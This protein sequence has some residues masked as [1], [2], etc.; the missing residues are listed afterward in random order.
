MNLL[1]QHPAITAIV[2]YW[3]F[4]SVV[5]GM[6]APT[7]SSSASYVWLHDSLHI[8]AGNVTTAFQARFPQLPINVPPGS[9]VQQTT[10]QKTTVVTPDEVKE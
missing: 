9:T 1:E 8:L 3:V 5:G 4:S 6:P 2:A 10:N 7:A